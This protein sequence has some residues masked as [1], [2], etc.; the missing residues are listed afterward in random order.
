MRTLT[1]IALCL[2]ISACTSAV[3]L[4]N[5]RTGQTATCGPFTDTVNAPSREA[6]CI[7][8]F[9]RQGFERVPD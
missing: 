5:A 6:Q 9:Q 1:I 4:R 2:T 8:D 3:K 7:Q